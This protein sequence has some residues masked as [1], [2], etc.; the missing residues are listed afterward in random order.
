MKTAD[1]L[2]EPTTSCWPTPPTGWFYPFNCHPLSSL[3]C[4]VD[5]VRVAQQ[6]YICVLVLFLTDT[7]YLGLLGS[8]SE[9]PPHF[10]SV[11]LHYCWCTTICVSD[12]W[13]QC[14]FFL[15]IFFNHDYY[16][17]TSVGCI[18]EGKLWIHKH[19]LNKLSFTHT[20]AP[21]TTHD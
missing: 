1:S 6:R 15:Y 18:L 4:R 14:T 11:S 2:S 10:V 17:L 21:G 9:Q 7:W 20:H 12:S 16:C 8:H 5:S 13:H 19:D 3:G